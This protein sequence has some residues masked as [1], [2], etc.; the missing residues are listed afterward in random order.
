MSCDENGTSL[1]VSLGDQQVLCPPGGFI[2]FASTQAWDPP[3]ST[4]LGTLTQGRIGP[5]PDAQH[6]AAMC[7]NLACANDCNG[8]G[9]CDGGTCKCYLGYRGPQC[10]HKAGP[11]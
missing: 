6:A 3:A 1:R 9:D 8:R 11:G 10:E 4:T 5:C 7:H 2:D